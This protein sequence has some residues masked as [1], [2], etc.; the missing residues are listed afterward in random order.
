MKIIIA[1]NI[2]FM[3]LGGIALILCFLAHIKNNN[4]IDNILLIDRAIYKYALDCWD[5]QRPQLVDYSDMRSYD[6]TFCRIFDWGYENILPKDKFEIVRQYI[7][8]RNKHQIL[9]GE[10]V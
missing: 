4:T 9:F 5:N 7:V 3:S 2:I 1:I 10:G 8:D 6:S